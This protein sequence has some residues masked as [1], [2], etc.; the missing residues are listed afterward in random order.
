VNAW[1]GFYAFEAE[2]RGAA[3]VTALDYFVWSM[4][5]K[6]HIK[7]WE[8][9]KAK[10]VNPGPYEKMPYFRPKELP[11]KIGF[12]TAKELRGSGV[13]Q[14]VGDFMEMDLDSLGQYDVTFFLGSLYH[15]QNPFESLK[16]L[17]KVTKEVAVI[18]TEASEFPGFHSTALCEFFESNELNGDTSNWWAPNEKALAGMCRAAGFRRTE[19]V[20]GPKIWSR[21]KLLSIAKNLYLFKKASPVW[22]YRTIIH[23]FK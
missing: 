10:G 21:S 5:I 1:D 19:T 4:D 23:A 9:C 18:E 2:R 14:V 22:R 6:E 13:K 8:E 17:A 16:R 7:W 3:S 11:G 20:K 12:D 15:M